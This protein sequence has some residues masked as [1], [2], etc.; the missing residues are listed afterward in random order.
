MTQP[1]ERSKQGNA[2]A[3]KKPQAGQN[4]Q[5]HHPAYGDPEPVHGAAGAVD[6]DQQ[7]AG[8]GG[9]GRKPSPTG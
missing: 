6:S 3:Q 1:N 9:R 8:I 5:N 7:A 4:T 2:Q